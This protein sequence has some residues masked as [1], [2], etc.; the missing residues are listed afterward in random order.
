MKDNAMSKKRNGTVVYALAG[1]SL[2]AALR[3]EQELRKELETVPVMQSGNMKAIGD[4]W[5]AMYKG[6]LA[7]L[8]NEAP[9]V[10]ELTG[11]KNPSVQVFKGP[12][13]Y[14]RAYVEYPQIFSSPEKEPKYFMYAPAD[15][16]G[17]HFTP[18]DAMRLN[19][20]EEQ[21]VGNLLFAG[22]WLGNAPIVSVKKSGV[23][24][25]ADYIAPSESE[26]RKAFSYMPNDRVCFLAAGRSLEI[27]EDYRARTKEWEQ[28]IND[29]CRAIEFETLK[30][31]PAVLLGLPAGEDVRI[32]ATY[33][34]SSGGGDKVTLLLSIRREGKNSMWDAGKTVDAVPSPAYDLSNRDGGEYIVTAR[35]D[36]PEGRDL[37]ALIDAI[38][39]TPGLRDY[40][41]LNANFDVKLDQIGRMLGVNGT[42]PQAVETGGRTVLVYSASPDEKT[43]GFCPPGAK[44]FPAE[45]YEWLRFDEGDRNMGITPPPMPKYIAD[46]LAAADSAE[47]VVKKRQP[48]P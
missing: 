45:A 5:D 46:I 26:L 25:P 36:T 40:P 13:T 29:A 23:A 33:S 41:E 35:T 43:T 38:P 34:Y 24:T 47:V 18:P 12:Q 42:V 11:L 19:D 28:K 3:L 10:L 31:K 32:S 2:D 15:Y 22:G 20:K 6:L 1:R 27:V 37:A 44:P 30:T 8:E 7:R 9:E 21:R 39:L 4:S 48:K 14:P 16:K 17:A